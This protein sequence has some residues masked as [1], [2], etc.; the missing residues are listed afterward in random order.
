MTKPLT[1]AKELCRV[2]DWSLSNLAIHKILYLAHMIYMGRNNGE[3][4]I[5]DAFQAWDYGPVLP[6]VYHN[7]KVFGDK[8]VK[9]IF[10]RV[11]SIKEGSPQQE[12]ILEAYENLCE[13]SPGELV[14]ITHWPEGAWA[15]S[16][17]SGRKNVV[18]PDEDILREYNERLTN[19]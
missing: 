7:A 5:D 16:Y 4:L 10:H 8:P 6:T 3:L 17:K 11:P 14:S 9:N 1:A 13:L 12:I 2:S 15:R 18:I 19:G